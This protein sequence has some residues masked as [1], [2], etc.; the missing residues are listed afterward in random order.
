MGTEVTLVSHAMRVLMQLAAVCSP[1][2]DARHRQI[3]SA[4]GTLRATAPGAIS[5]ASGEGCSVHAAVDKL[6]MS[7]EPSPRL[8][9]SVGS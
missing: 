6:Q 1:R 2:G 8:I 7:M 5:R 9:V 3:A 4:S